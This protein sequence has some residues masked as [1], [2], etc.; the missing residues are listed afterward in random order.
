MAAP[1][2]VGDEGFPTTVGML[3]FQAEDEP[4]QAHRPGAV[5]VP[6][7]EH[8]SANHVLSRGENIRQVERIAFRPPRIVRCRSPLDALAIDFQPVAAFAEDPAAGGFRRGVQFELAPEKDRRVRQ[9]AVR[10]IPDPLGWREIQRA[11]IDRL[12][13][14]QGAG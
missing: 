4:R 12:R 8:G 1:A 9:G 2:I 5:A 11:E 7:K 3:N 14:N 6:E 13:I 10:R